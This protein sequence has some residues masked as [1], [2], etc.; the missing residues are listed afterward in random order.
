LDN[1]EDDDDDDDG[2]GGGGGVGLLKHVKRVIPVYHIRARHHLISSTA[3]MNYHA[4]T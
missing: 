3:T 1:D 2:G 4:H